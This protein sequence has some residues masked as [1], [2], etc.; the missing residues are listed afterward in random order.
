MFKAQ[1][2]IFNSAIIENQTYLK[3]WQSNTPPAARKSQLLGMDQL[4]E[5]VTDYQYIY[6]LNESNVKSSNVKN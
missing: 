4:L 1:L 3:P 6:N 2:I 5:I